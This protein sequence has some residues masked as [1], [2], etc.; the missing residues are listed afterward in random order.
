MLAEDGSPLLGLFGDGGDVGL[1]LQGDLSQK[2]KLSEI[3]LRLRVVE[4]APAVR[5]PVCVQTVTTVD[6]ASGGPVMR[7]LWE[8]HRWIP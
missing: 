2:Q 6:E 3:T 8:L 5:P 7:K 4:T 1:Q